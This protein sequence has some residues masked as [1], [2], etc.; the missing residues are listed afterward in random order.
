MSIPEVQNRHTSGGEKM[1]IEEIVVHLAKTG[2]WPAT[3]SRPLCTP[4]TVIDS[5]DYS[6]RRR[7]VRALGGDCYSFIPL[8]SDQL[9]WVVG[10]G[11]GKGL[12]AAPMIANV[13]SSLR[14][15][16]LFTGDDLARLLRAVNHQA[17]STSLATRYATLF[18]RVFDNAKPT[19]PYNTP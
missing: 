15:A 10:D 11:S 19:L 12:A 6:A 16:P 2:Y 13:Q 18:Y 1:T 7:Q 3:S 17:Y 4:C 8:K 9:A 14:T 5:L